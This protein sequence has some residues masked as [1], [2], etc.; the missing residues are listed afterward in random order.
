MDL[1]KNRTAL[2]IAAGK[3][4]SAIQ[5]EYIAELGEPGCD[6]SECVMHSSHRLLQA[7]KSGELSKVLDTK[8][9]A[10]FLGKSWVQNHTN[11]LPF[12]AELERLRR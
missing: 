9:V 10:E 6:E 4:I 1:T 11:V 8:S 2:E 3:L 12:I 7:A 5:K